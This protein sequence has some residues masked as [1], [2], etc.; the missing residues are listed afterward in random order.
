MGLPGL[1][2]GPVFFFKRIRRS[3]LD[4]KLYVGNLSYETSEDGLREL[5]SQVGNV[6]SV[7]LIK[8]RDTGRSKGFGFVEMSTQNEAE[9]A[10]KQFNGFSYE[11]RA[12]KVDKARPPEENSY[13]RGGSQ[14]YGQ[15]GSWNDRRQT[16]SGKK[17][18]RY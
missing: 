16:G 10:I 12:L 9:A 14:R 18:R 4:T 17:N 8:D 6:A 13:A 7:T 1:C 11:N 2:E 5:F 3:I 15:R